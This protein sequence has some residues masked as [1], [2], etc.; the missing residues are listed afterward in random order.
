MR[1]I[2]TIWNYLLAAVLT[3]FIMT[4]PAWG[5]VMSKGA[6]KD[7]HRYLEKAPWIG[8]IANELTFGPLTISRINI[9]D[10]EKFA[11][12]APGEVL[13]GSL[14]YSINA[15]ELSTLHRYHLVIGIDGEGAQDCV[16]HTIGICNS[17]GIGNFKLTAPEKAGIYQV[18][19]MF[20]EGLTCSRAQELWNSGEKEPSSEATIGVIIVE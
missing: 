18:K 13:E 3:V 6:K 9:H 2:Q 17:K 14:Q 8:L 1:S 12:V 20:V 4:T 19:F 10:G 5:S 11:L 7:I 15:K 16:T